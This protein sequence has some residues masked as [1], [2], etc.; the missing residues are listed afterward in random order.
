VTEYVSCSEWIVF[1]HKGETAYVCI[2]IIF[3][4]EAGVVS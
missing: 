3:M 2:K 4:C 1:K